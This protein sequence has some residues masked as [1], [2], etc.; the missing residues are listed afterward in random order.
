MNY[1]YILSLLFL[2][3]E[4]VSAQGNTSDDLTPLWIVIVVVVVLCFII[5]MCSGNK[6]TYK[7][8]EYN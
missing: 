5:N 2:F 8:A 1:I 3:F 7:R 4:V 6:S